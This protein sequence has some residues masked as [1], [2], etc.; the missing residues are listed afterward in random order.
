MCFGGGTTN[1]TTNSYRPLT[2]DELRAQHNST[3][4]AESLIPTAN[5][6]VNQATQGF[7]TASTY[8]PNYANLANQQ[9][10]AT[11]QNTTNAQNIS[12]GMLPQAFN[13]NRNAQ[14][15][16]YA[17]SAVGGLLNNMNQRGV[18]NSSVMGS[19][20]HDINTTMANAFTNSYNTDLN[21]ASNMNNNNQ[22]YANM[23]IQQANQAQQASYQNPLQLYGAA[24]GQMQPSQQ[25][26]QP[27]MLS[28][29]QNPTS[30][31]QTASGQGLF[32]G[33]VSGLGSYVKAGGTF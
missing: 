10:Q 30:S 2:A 32:S 21:T 26:W 3:N 24:T 7:N 16:T 9:A 8:N 28:N 4:Y 11:A 18:V 12:N 33:L 27:S 22:Q 6:M 1:T 25:I 17:D 5:A 29:N 15:K 19:G 20:L 31:T 23:P 13:D 14:A